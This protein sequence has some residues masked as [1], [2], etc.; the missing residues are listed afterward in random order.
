MLFDLASCVPGPHGPCSPQSCQDQ[1][2]DCGPAGDGCGNVIQC[3]TCTVPGQ[4]CGGG[5]YG[6]C[7]GP[8]AGVCVPQTCNELH[9]NCGIE[10]DGCGGIINCGTCSPPAICGGGGQPSVCGT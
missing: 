7:G 1:G 8:D 5:G 2:I 6:L 10:G 4:V 9:H 3:G